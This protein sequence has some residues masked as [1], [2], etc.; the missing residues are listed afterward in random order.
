M[1]FYSY[2]Y[3]VTLYA[4]W[5][6]PNQISSFSYENQAEKNMLK[7]YDFLMFINS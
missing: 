1:L 4:V 6:G 2:I 3:W 5:E 7:I